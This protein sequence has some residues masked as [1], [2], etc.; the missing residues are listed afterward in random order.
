VQTVLLQ[1]EALAAAHARIRALDGAGSE[2]GF[3]DTMRDTLFGRSEPRGAVPTVRPADAPM[4]VPRGWRS[5]AAAAPTEA[6]A[7]RPGGSFLGT[8]AATAAGVVMGAL[9]YDAF[10][11]LGRPANAAEPATPARDSQAGLDQSGSGPHGDDTREAPGLYKPADD[12]DQDWDS[13]DVDIGD[14]A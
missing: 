11:S 14:V 1:D 3:L 6:P 10:R 2:G 13:G 5:R 8:A 4:G 12:I 7:Q 9:A